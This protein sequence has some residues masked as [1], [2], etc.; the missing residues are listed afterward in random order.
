MKYVLYFALLYVLLPLN[1]L[2]DFIIILMFFVAINEHADFAIIYAFI[3]GLLVDLYYPSTLGMNMLLFVILVQ[4]LLIIK[5]YVTKT[6]IM[7]F[8]LFTVF[9]LLKVIVHHMVVAFPT[10]IPF[11]LVSL[12][13][14]FP[15][16]CLVHRIVYRTWMRT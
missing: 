12:L 10:S 6:P 4:I 16:F 13:C 3:A 8:A 5:T 15:V 2:A 1:T 11:L 7:V 14:F 9:F